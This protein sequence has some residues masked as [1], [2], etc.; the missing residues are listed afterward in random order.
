MARTK[1]SVS[2]V[3][4]ISLVVALA[5]TA[6]AY[7]GT[8]WAGTY[9]VE[10]CD[11]APAGGSLAWASVNSNPA[12]LSTTL[13][14]PPS[15]TYT[16][17]SVNDVL[18]SSSDATFGARAGWTFSAP[19]DTEITR[20]KVSRYLGKRGT[21]TWQVTGAVDG[22]IVDTCTIPPGSDICTR[23]APQS[24]TDVIEFSPL[25]ASKVEYAV[26]CIAQDADCIDGFDLHHAWVSLYGSWVTLQDSRTP[27]LSAISGELADGG[28]RGWHHGA[29]AATFGATEHTG[30]KTTRVLIDAATARGTV[31]HPCDFSK[32]IPCA[33]VPPM[34]H[35]VDLS[36]ISDGQHEIRAS[37]V[38]AGGDETQSSPVTIKVDNTPPGAPQGLTVDGGEGWR[39]ATSFGL[40]WTN[41]SAGQGA[42][43]DAVHWRLCPVGSMVGCTE[44]RQAG[45]DIERALVTPPSDGE[46]SV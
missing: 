17:I 35:A 41:P 23:G 40:S 31:E 38:D 15:G 5:L 43:V 1:K 19:A 21:N 29:E 37:A 16:G 27:L 33:D 46:W 2:C 18:Q 4:R 26:E 22:V 6:A 32:P 34:A 42:P 20:L 28:T 8:A 7:C 36:E 13:S 14:C 39:S 3:L 25:A 12:V 10:S 11:A 30:I 44:G 9:T 24:G 45:A